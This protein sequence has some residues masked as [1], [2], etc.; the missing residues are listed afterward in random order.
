MKHYGHFIG[1]EWISSTDTIDSINPASAKTWATFAAG[2]AQTADHAIKTA[3]AAFTNEWREFNPEQR[4]DVID[5]LATALETHWESLVAAEV[6]DNGKRIAEVRGQFAG[7]H[8]WF[9]H[10]ANEARNMTP[11]AQT[12]GVPGVESTLHHLPYGVV[13][14]ITPWNSPLMILAWKLAPALAA[15]NTVVVKP[16]EMASASTLEFAKL[17]FEAGVPAGVLNVVTGYGHTVGEA[18]VRHPLTR[19]VTFTGSDFGG[20]KVAEAAANGVVPC[21]LELGGKS[22]QVVF[23]DA[24]LDNTVNGIL[25]GIFLSNGQTCVAGSRLIVEKTIKNALTQRLLDVA[26]G[27][28]L[29]DPMDAETQIGPLA[30]EAHLRKVTEMVATAQSEGA[31]CLLDGRE[32]AQGHEGYYFGPTIFDGVTQNMQL[33][34]EEVFGPVLAITSFETEAEAVSLANDSDYGL[35]G[36]VWTQDPR[37]GARVAAQIDAGTV[38]VN[39][40][41][42]VDP[43]VPIGGI[44]LSGYG[45]ELG[46]NAI[47]DFLQTK[48]IWIGSAPVAVPFP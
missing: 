44:K 29:G 16:S 6:S 46:P 5:R 36:G 1:G 2:D 17:A 24:D 26:G 9:R 7:L 13:V 21:V 18:L 30:N 39:H 41:R 27:L 37:K 4:A 43:N 19:K 25:S 10:F 33:W 48:S 38:Y 47:K 45:R 12:N 20:R 22:A 11:E 23:A 32:T 8:T 40:Y 42:S 35:A 28:R 3:H 14:A 15:G 31:R 34:R